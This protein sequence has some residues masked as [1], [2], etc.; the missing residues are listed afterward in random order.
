M[1]CQ[2]AS[3]VRF[4]AAPAGPDP[5]RYANRHAHCEVLV[6]GAGPAGLA[7]ALAASADG[8]KRVILADEQS[9]PGGSLLHDATSGIDG[10]PAREWLLDALATLDGRENVVILPRTTAFGAC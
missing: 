6:V 1:S 8:S 3:A 4:G 5:D 2:I 7:A 9:E 10:R